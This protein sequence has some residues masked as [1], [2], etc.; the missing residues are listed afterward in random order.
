M[1]WHPVFRNK[2]D[3]AH[4]LFVETCFDV[5]SCKGSN[6]DV[7]LNNQKIASFVPAVDCLW[8]QQDQN[9]TKRRVDSTYQGAQHVAWG[10]ALIYSLFENPASVQLKITRTKCHWRWAIRATCGKLTCRIVSLQI[11]IFALFYLEIQSAVLF[12]TIQ[13]QADYMIVLVWLIL[14]I[15]VSSCQHTSP[16]YKTDT[17]LRN[18]LRHQSPINL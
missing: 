14:N 9:R 2:R 16:P 17:E 8:R 3:N 10:A 11:T 12:S 13:W 15:Q 18:S 6:C 4:A 1:V 7:M 5:Q